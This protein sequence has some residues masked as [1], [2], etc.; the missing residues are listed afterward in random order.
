MLARKRKQ[1][2]VRRQPNGQPAR[3]RPAV[4]DDIMGVVKAQRLRLVPERQVMEQSA[5]NPLGIY[6]LKGWILQHHEDA[7]REYARVVAAVKRDDDS[8]SEDARNRV[9]A[10]FMPIRCSPSSRDDLSDAELR[11]KRRERKR[12]YDAAYA[13]L[14]EQGYWVLDAVLTVALRERVD[15]P[16][17]DGQAA[18]G[19]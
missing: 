16:R 17:E 13:V 18:A 19:A 3:S 4:R 10:N 6:R 11:E 12:R 5:E 7:G 9:L 15:S 8:P 14:R 2:L 1:R